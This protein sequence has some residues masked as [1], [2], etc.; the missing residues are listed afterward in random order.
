M[1]NSTDGEARILIV[2][3]LLS[4][5]HSNQRFVRKRIYLHLSFSLSALCFF[6]SELSLQNA[7]LS[8]EIN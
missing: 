3:R 4:D 6:F 2:A 1:K 7:H 5:V 8:S